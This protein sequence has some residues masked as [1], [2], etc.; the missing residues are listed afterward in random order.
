MMEVVTKLWVF[1][2]PVLIFQ[3]EIIPGTFLLR[4]LNWKKKCMIKSRFQL[5]QMKNKCRTLTEFSLLMRG[6]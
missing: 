1:R 5:I 6:R 4:V 3:E 2:C